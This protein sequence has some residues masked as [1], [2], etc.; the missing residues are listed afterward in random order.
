MGVRGVI[1][2]E[3][4][5]RVFVLRVRVTAEGYA[6]RAHRRSG[7]AQKVSGYEKAPF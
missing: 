3:R 7:T 2:E 4:K 6:W 5:A 1:W